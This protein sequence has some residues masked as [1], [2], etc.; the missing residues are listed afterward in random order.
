MASRSRLVAVRTRTKVS[1]FQD[2]KKELF[3]L[4]YLY[5]CRMSEHPKYVHYLLI[6]TVDFTLWHVLTSYF[7]S[8]LRHK[9]LSCYQ[10]LAS[11]MLFPP[12]E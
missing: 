3:I 5:S 12:L 6:V 1:R 4:S 7:K 11:I 2:Y 8:I 9:Q 10:T